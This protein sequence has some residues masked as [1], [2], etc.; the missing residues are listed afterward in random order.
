MNAS[1]SNTFVNFLRLGK[2]RDCYKIESKFV[3]KYAVYIWIL[4]RR[5]VS[6]VV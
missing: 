3:V 4:N 6:V 2:F 5:K 1:P